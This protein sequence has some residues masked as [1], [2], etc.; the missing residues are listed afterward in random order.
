MIRAT[1]TAAEARRR[2]YSCGNPNTGGL[3]VEIQP[4]VAAADTHSRPPTL[5]F[6]LCPA[7]RD[8]TVCRFGVNQEAL[9]AAREEV[10]RLRE[11]NEGLIAAVRD[12]VAALRETEAVRKSLADLAHA[13]GA[14]VGD[15]GGPG[16]AASAG[17]TT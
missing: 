10:H 15:E 14:I 4:D 11:T 17:G 7:C 9:A 6:A 16:T 2:C 1:P 3:Q 8:L 12:A 5:T 13:I